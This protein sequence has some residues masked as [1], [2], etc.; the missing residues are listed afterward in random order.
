MSQP[1]PQVLQTYTLLQIA[2]EAFLGRDPEDPAARPG[3]TPEVQLGFQMLK[4][5]NGH[6]S[7]MTHQQAKDFEA[8]WEVISHQ[9]NTATGFSA[10]LFKLKQGRADASKGTHEGQLV[11]SF[12]ST[13]FIE[14]HARDNH[15]TNQMEISQAGWAFGQLADMQIWWDSVKT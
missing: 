13:E 15:A 4:A 8:D 6:S 5:G 7:R 11:V 1:S 14:D 12:R 10:T 2:A 9:A 3:V